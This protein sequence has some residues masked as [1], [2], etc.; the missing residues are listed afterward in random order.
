MLSLKFSE[1]A[2]VSAQIYDKLLATALAII[3]LFC[4]VT[5]ILSVTS[6]PKSF[7]RF[8]ILLITSRAIPSS[9]NSVLMFTS[10]A[11]V[12]FPKLVTCQPGTS[13][14]IISTSSVVIW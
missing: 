12:S 6:K 8:W 14:A 13:S 1:V 7:L 11:T 4:K 5:L 10:K 3:G 9:F 2:K